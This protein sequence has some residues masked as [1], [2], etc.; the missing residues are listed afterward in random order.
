MGVSEMRW[1]TCGKMMDWPHVEENR[2]ACGQDSPRMEPTG[3]VQERETPTHLE[4]H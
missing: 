1:N 3:E 2:L 4:T